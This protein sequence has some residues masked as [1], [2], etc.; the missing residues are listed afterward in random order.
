MRALAEHGPCPEHR[1]SFVNVRGLQA[2]PTWRLVPDQLRGSM[3]SCYPPGS[4]QN[5]PIVDVIEE[6]DWPTAGFAAM[7][8]GA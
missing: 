5:G 6:H 3:N 1:M 2:W 8:R 7:A 4:G